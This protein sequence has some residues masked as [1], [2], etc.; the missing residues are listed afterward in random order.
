MF[1]RNIV[2][3]IVFGLDWIYGS[4]LVYGFLRETVSDSFFLDFCFLVYELV[5]L[6]FKSNEYPVDRKEK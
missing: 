1:L 3:G 4:I 2:Y 6:Y 5:A